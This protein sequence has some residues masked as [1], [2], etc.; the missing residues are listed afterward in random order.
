MC[1]LCSG[2]ET[3]RI[4]ERKRLQYQAS[5]LRN[6]ADEIDALSNGQIKPHT[7]RAKLVTTR[8]TMAIKTLAEDW[9]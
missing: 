8:A 4:V 5:L 3:E 9:L 2:E 1:M 6:L 7:E